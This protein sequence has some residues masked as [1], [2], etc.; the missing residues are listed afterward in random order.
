MSIHP[1][2]AEGILSGAKRVEFRK[3]RIADDVTHVVVYATAPVSAVVGAFTVEEQHTLTT[4]SLWQR[5]RHIA[6]IG[7]RDFMSYYTGYTSGTGIAVGEV[8]RAP[9]PLCLQSRLG[10]ARPPQSFQ[11]LSAETA[12]SALDLMEPTLATA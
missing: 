4:P 8:L 2:Y 9:E 3:R 10:I 1:Q 6:G 5:F 11:Y 12:R 7:K